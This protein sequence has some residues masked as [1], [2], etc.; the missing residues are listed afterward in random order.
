MA[1]GKKDK[2]FL[3]EYRYGG[4][5]W[6]LTIWAEDADSAMR[7]LRAAAT[8]GGVIGEAVIHANVPGPFER[9]GRALGLVA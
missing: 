4:S 8:N 6:L 9:I 3:I 2:R 7:K 1:E 5:E